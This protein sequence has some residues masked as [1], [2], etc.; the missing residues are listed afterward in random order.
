V[1]A[2]QF[3]GLEMHQDLE[4]GC[5]HGRMPDL[6]GVMSEHDASV[7]SPEQ[8]FTK[9]FTDSYE[10]VLAFARRRVEA[11]LAQDIVAGGRQ[12]RIG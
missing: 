6:Y 7:W 4:S 3:T 9:L 10:R 8:R 11:D 2:N 12:P 5:N 1:E